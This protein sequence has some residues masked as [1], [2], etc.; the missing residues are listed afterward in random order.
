MRPV[1]HDDQVTDRFELVPHGFD[2]RHE[3]QVHTQCPILRVV[4]DVGQLRL[5]QTRIDRVHH[6]THARHPVVQLEM[7][8]RVP[9]NG[10]DRV[11]LAQFEA[12]ER[13]SQL[14]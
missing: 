13:L 2:E 7:P 8:V 3:G 9:G 5:V 12:L 1:S 6:G 4:E 14:R 11:A 10:R